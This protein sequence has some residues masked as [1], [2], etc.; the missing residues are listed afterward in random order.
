MTQDLD[1]PEH[2]I[3]NCANW[4]VVA[5]RPRMELTARNNLERQGYTVWLPELTLKKRRKG[6]W[7]SVVEPMF[8]G[9]VFTQ[10]V[11]GEEDPAPIRST[12]GCR[13]LVRF[14]VEYPPVPEELMAALFSASHGA[15][16][17]TS[18]NESIFTTGEWVLL[19][20]GPFAGLSAVFEMPLGEDRARVLIDLLGAE[21]SVEVRMDDLGPGD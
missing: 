13:G 7:T 16:L 14:G 20:S 18:D 2:P 3:P 6:K 21:R 5:T 1:N 15:A 10:L 12:L 11:F 4:Y 17:Q 19:E 8:P 9:Y